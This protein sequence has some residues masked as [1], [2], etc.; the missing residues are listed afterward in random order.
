MTESLVLSD[1]WGLRVRQELLVREESKDLQASQ[2]LLARRVLQGPSVRQE[3]KVRREI[4]GREGLTVIRE[5]Q[6][7]REQWV[8]SDR[9]DRRARKENREVL[10]CRLTKS[11][12]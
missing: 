5:P 8:Q 9:Q 1:R 6:A 10:A 2:G 4:Q 12:R 11:K 7:L 3:L